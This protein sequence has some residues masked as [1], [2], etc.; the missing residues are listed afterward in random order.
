MKSFLLSL[1]VSA[2]IL[3]SAQEVVFHVNPG[4]ELQSV[5]EGIRAQRNDG[6]LT[7]NDSV[8]VVFAPGDYMLDRAIELDARDSGSERSPFVWRAEKPG[9]V[10]FIG[11]RL[12]PRDAFK[13]VS[14]AGCERL[15][16]AVRGKVLEADVTSYLALDPRPWPDHPTGVML[17]VW[18]YHDGR[19]QTIARWPNRD[20]VDGGWFG[21]SNVLENCGWQ[22]DCEKPAVFEFPGDRPLR[23]RFNE[24]VWVT[25]YLIVDWDCDTVRIA[26]YDKATH[27]A[28]L[29]SA[30][31][32]GV[33]K[34]DWPFYKRRIFV[35]NLLEELDQEEEW[36]LD[37]NAKR[38]YWWPSS[39]ELDGEIALA[40]ALTPYFRIK[41]AHDIVLDGISFAYSHGDTAIVL[42]D[43]ERCV[44]RHCGFSNHGGKAITVTGRR[45][46]I[47][48]CTMKNLGETAVVLDGGSTKD[49]LPANNIVE[50]C[51]IENIS[52]YKRTASP[53]IVLSGC[54]NAVRGN[55]LLYSPDKAVQ[56]SGNEHLIADNEFGF[57]TQ[58]AGDTGAIYSGHHAEW[59]GTILFG[60]YIHDLA[61]TPIECDSRSAIY[62]DDC[63]WGDDVI[64]NVFRHAGRGVLIGGGKLHGVYN[65][66]VSESYCGVHIDARGYLWRAKKNGSFYWDKDGRPF[67]R[68]R[69]A[70]AGINPGRPPYSVVYP[71]LRE[72]M[73]KHPEFPY[74]N[75]V[76]GNV[77][78][79]CKVP[80]AYSEEAQMAIGS[81]TPG[82]VVVTNAA[83]A[84][85]RAPQPIQLKDAVRNRL[86]SA[87]GSTKVF[88][89]LDETAHLVWAL[90]VDGHRVL[91]LS[92]LGITVDDFDYGRRVVPEAAQDRGEVDLYPAYTN[93]TV[94]V[95]IRGGIGFRSGTK[96][97][98]S[99]LVQKAREWRIPLR[100]LL[101][102][103]RVASLDFRLWRDG[104]AYRW[105]IPGEG[106]RSVA[107]EN[108]SFVA[109]DPSRLGFMLVEWERDAALVNG[110][111]EVFYYKRAEGVTGVLFPEATHGWKHVGEVV[112]PWRGVLCKEEGRR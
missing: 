95:P 80:F 38:L 61:K 69:F 28:R 96:D 10:R 21:F 94:L 17:G 14:G 78:A 22:L 44:V 46:R 6:R 3:L 35:Q 91:D 11:G 81:S 50:K 32:W 109:A 9:R 83:T 51:Q 84:S 112:S 89:G 26:S 77:F 18:L 73:E 66:L 45:N 82:N 74:M 64:G 85:A 107:G 25:G 40:Q 41:G 16:P 1:V 92:P 19:S 7:T 43:C 104:A 56:Y 52:M 103:E 62:F 75:A 57:V 72:A 86:A 47:F 70:E 105:T 59:L 63:D 27:G 55:T 5:L 12:I 97:V 34:A 13:P 2:S 106:E 20:A 53:G 54:G 60:N 49:L 68:Y 33:G 90:K 8:S 76:T 93:A 110:Y 39:K 37:R 98:S 67:C 87:D 79:A 48:K 108:D 36:Y 101:T 15:D 24:G 30:T 102:G 58:E 111:P 23:W 88:V 100:S 65:N 29:A 42:E 31:T 71:G 4:D 99:S